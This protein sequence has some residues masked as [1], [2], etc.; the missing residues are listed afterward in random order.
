MSQAVTRTRTRGL[1]YQPEIL[2]K[3][4]SLYNAGVRVKEIAR[5]LGYTGGGS[6]SVP[7]A[8]L[9]KEGRIG[10]RLP[11]L[12]GNNHRTSVEAEAYA[13]TKKR[14]EDL[15]NKG[16][17]R[18]EIA[19]HM[20][21]TYAA[22]ATCLWR[23][24]KKMEGTKTPDAQQMSLLDLIEAQ[25]APAAKTETPAAL[26]APVSVPTTHVTTSVDEA[27]SKLREEKAGWVQMYEELKAKLSALDEAIEK[28]ED[29]KEVLG[30]MGA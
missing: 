8:M 5:T 22:V 12:I 10:T 25:P 11:R 6:L 29:A 21:M 16:W 4:A 2:D 27:L 19:N 23:E 1:V 28:L 20:G 15:S 17:T 18:E 9:R 26:P 7:L 24:R 13:Q 3:I 14:I 30:G